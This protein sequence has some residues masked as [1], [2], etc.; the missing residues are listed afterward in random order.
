MNLHIAIHDTEP[1]EHV[2]LKG[3]DAWALLQLMTAGEK[4]CT[5]MDNP[6]PRWSAYVHNLRNLG[7]RIETV[8]EHHGGAFKG[9]HGRYVLR[10]SVKL[11]EGV[12]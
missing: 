4:G 12:E 9:V 7:I 2:T 8:H 10:S 6:G 1:A 11:A 5:P 3:R